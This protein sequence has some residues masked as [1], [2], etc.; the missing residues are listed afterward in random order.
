MLVYKSL[1]IRPTPS[2]AYS[3]AATITSPSLR[4]GIERKD[5]PSKSPTSNLIDY[6]LSIITYT[7]NSFNI[8]QNIC[9]L[10]LLK[11][12]YKSYNASWTEYLIKI[13]LFNPG[14]KYPIALKFLPSTI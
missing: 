11:I 13:T 7:V 1:F 2:F 10:F 9:L 8:F 6:F 3:L 14:S 5:L 12:A 4:V